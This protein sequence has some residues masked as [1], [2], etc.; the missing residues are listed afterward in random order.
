MTK[1]EKEIKEN[2]R[3]WDFIIHALVKEYGSKDFYK[4]FRNEEYIMTE[5]LFQEWKDDYVNGTWMV[6]PEEFVN[7]ALKTKMEFEIKYKFDTWRSP[8]NIK[9]ESR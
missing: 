2:F 5:E 4:R 9:R 3:P 6:D 7:F 1:K 8:R